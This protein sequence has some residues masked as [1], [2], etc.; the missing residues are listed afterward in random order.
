[1]P[2]QSAG[3]DLYCQ[4]GVSPTLQVTEDLETTMH[5]AATTHE[6]GTSAKVYTYEADFD[7]H[8]DTI[9]WQAQVCHAQEQPRAISGTIPITSPA[10]GAL[11]EK[12]V[13]DTIVKQIDQ[14]A[15]TGQR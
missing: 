3:G 8:Q 14:L 13:R 9:A 15:L 12:V 4:H 1:V 5:I 2:T 6:Q 7:V 11:A 10:I